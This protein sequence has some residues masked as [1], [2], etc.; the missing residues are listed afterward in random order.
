MAIN[1]PF[2]LTE[3]FDELNTRTPLLVTRGGVLYLT[4]KKHAFD[5]S[6]YRFQERRCAMK[7]LVVLIILGAAGFVAYNYFTSGEISLMPSTSQS[8]EEQ[9]LKKLEKAFQEAKN[10]YL[11]GSRGASLVGIDTP[12]DVVGAIREITRVEREVIA[13]KARMTSGKAK[14]KAEKLLIEIRAFMKLHG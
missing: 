3:G 10:Q 4:Y 11:Q 13:L 14:V 6:H 1:C 12:A 2:T 8:P 7:K 5:K 9:E